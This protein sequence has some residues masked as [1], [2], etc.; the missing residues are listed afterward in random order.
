MENYLKEKHRREKL[1]QIFN[2][3]ING[4]GYFQCDSFKWKNIAFRHYNKIKRKE[5][6]VEQLVLAIQKEGIH[7]TQHPS[8][9]KYPLI[10][11]LIHIAKTCKETIEI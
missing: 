7:F 4:E 1:E 3:T 8:L 10:D 6:S 9:M 5:M 2:R 11:F